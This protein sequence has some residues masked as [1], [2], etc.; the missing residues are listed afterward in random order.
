MVYLVQ[1]TH[2]LSQLT[3]RNVE[4]YRVKRLYVRTYSTYQGIS[5]TSIA[6]PGTS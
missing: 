1:I 3:T 4:N 5:S 2:D 6:V